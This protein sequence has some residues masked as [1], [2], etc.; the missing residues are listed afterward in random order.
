MSALLFGDAFEPGHHVAAVETALLQALTHHGPHVF[1]DPAQHLGTT[2]F[3]H[4]AVT[5]QPLRFSLR[6]IDLI[7]W[8]EWNRWVDARQRWPSD[9]PPTPGEPSQMALDLLRKA[10]GAGGDW[11]R[12][13]H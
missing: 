8:S 4:Y 12:S 13:N 1:G 10:A 9:C 3:T 11:V 5:V 6:L 7:P 2:D